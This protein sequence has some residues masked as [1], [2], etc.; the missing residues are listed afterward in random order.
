MTCFVAGVVI[1]VLCNRYFRI[2]TTSGSD[3][4]GCIVDHSTFIPRIPYGLTNTQLYW[5]SSRRDCTLLSLNDFGGAELETF[6]F[7]FYTLFSLAEERP[8]SHSRTR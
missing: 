6:F 2:R 1:R 4:M 8:E 3:R 5:P 7:L